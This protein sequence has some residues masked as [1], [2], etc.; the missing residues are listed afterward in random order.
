MCVCCFVGFLSLCF[1]FWM[2]MSQSCPPH[3]LWF[4]RKNVVIGTSQ[5]RAWYPPLCQDKG[6]TE[7]GTTSVLVFIL[8]LIQLGHVSA[9]CY[10]V[11]RGV[12][13]HYV[14]ATLLI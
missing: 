3:I 1:G 6:V 7:A 14:A 9:N 11:I 12:L 10:V 4:H 2:E 8:S 5:L 13:L